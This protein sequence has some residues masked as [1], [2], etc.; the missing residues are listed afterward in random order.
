MRY[1]PYHIKDDEK[2]TVQMFRGHLRKFQDGYSRIPKV[3]KFSDKHSK[4][5][6]SVDKNAKTETEALR[7]I[8]DSFERDFMV[9][10]FFNSTD[11]VME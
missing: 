10:V 5:I 7:K 3:I 4:E 6:A 8:K 2:F 11:T 1:G 9:H